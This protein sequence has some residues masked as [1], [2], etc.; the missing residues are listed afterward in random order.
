V[1]VITL[2]SLTGVAVTAPSSRDADAVPMTVDGSG[3]VDIEMK[4]IPL[5]PGPYLVHTEVTGWGRKRIYDHI[6]NARSFDVLAGDTSEKA[7]VVTLRPTWT[8]TGDGVS[9]DRYS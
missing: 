4:S 2:A 1:F 5:V 7:G 6:Q 9:P 3:H 8:W